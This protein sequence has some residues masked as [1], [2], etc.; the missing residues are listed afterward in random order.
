VRPDLERL[1]DAWQGAGG[2]AFKSRHRDWAGALGEMKE[3][4]ADL[5]KWAHRATA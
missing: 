2:S 1:G 4:L 3:Q 5:K